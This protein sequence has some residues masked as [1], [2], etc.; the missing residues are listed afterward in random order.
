VP[1][2]KKPKKPPTPA[3]PYEPDGAAI[4]RTVLEKAL[5]RPNDD[6]KGGK[7]PYASRFANEMAEQLANA[8]RLRY[9]DYFAEATASTEKAVETERGLH[10]LDVNFSRKKLGLGFG[11]SL[12]AVHFL[13]QT[14]KNYTHNPKRNDE[15][16]RVE[17]I[18]YHQRQPFAVMIGVV[19][20]PINALTD[21]TK[22]SSFGRWVKYMKPLAGREEPSDRYDLYERVFISCYDGTPGKEDLWFFDVMVPPPKR[23]K[24]KKV[25]T[26]GQF[27]DEVKAT[28]D[29]RNHAGF[30]WDDGTADD[31]TE[32]GDEAEADEEDA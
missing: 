30:K 8:I 29:K 26:I 7:G 21:G 25:L 15:E 32:E 14:S 28:Y 6:A 3:G 10:Q 9:P 16:L 24:P 19:F 5:P 31:T 22:T 17:S 11:I 4:I 27:F 1:S 2:K 13:D 20:L 23:E 18:G 12:K